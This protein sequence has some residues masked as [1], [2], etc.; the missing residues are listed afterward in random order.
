MA[1]QWA[2]CDSAF[3]AA[4]YDRL[5]GLIGFIDWLFFVPPDFRGRA[6]IEV[7]SQPGTPAYN[8]GQLGGEELHILAQIEMAS[9]T[10]TATASSAATTARSAASIGPS[11]CPSAASGISTTFGLPETPDSRRP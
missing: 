9:H 7:G 2:D 5:A 10:H 8:Y 6:P 3:I 1:Y 4:R 11:P